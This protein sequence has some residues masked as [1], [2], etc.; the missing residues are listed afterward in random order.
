MSTV[1][2]SPQPS[3]FASRVADWVTPVFMHAFEQSW[4][5]IWPRPVP[6]ASRRN[7]ILSDILGQTPNMYGY[8][9][10]AWTVVLLHQHLVQSLGLDV[11]LPTLANRLYA[12]NIQLPYTA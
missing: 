12:L 6:Q 2:S 3:R 10:A 1:I 7:N 8:R 4:Y 5:R 11:S 9:Q